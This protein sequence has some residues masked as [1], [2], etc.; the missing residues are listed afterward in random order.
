MRINYDDPNKIR[1]CDDITRWVSI[2]P[3]EKV[4]KL[5]EQQEQS[6]AG[7]SRAR[8][9]MPSRQRVSLRRKA[10]RSGPGPV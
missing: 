4:R 10:K 3:P 5:M 9:T 2:I 1:F 8:E 7:A 6:S